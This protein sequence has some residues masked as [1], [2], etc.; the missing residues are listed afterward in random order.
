MLDNSMIFWGPNVTTN[1]SKC[2]GLRYFSSMGGNVLALG[3][4]SLFND[5][6][7]EMIYPLLPLFLTETLGA[8]AAMLGVIE[9]IAESTASV[10]KLF[11]GWLSDRLRKRKILAVVGYTISTITRPLIAIATAGWH[12]LV[13]RFSDRVGKGVRTSPRDALLADSS[14]EAIRGKA[15]GFHRAMDHAGAVIGP[16][17][18]TAILAWITISYRTVFYLAVIPAIIG[19]LILI[20]RVVEKPPVG[21][22]A[23]A[24]KITLVNFDRP[25]RYYLGVVI[26]FT[27]GNS[28]DAFLILR[29][30]NLGVPIALIPTIWLVLHL[31]KML[32]ATPGGSLS[33]K[34][35]RKRVITLGWLVYALVYAGFA[36]ASEA[37]HAWALFVTYGLYFGL[38]EGTEKAFVADLVKPE[39]RGTAYGMFHFAVGIGA[40]PASVIMG[41]LWNAFGPAVAFGFGASLAL[42][43]TILLSLLREK[44]MRWDVTNYR[45]KK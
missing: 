17:L 5:I 4:V 33:D 32:T 11:S 24:P 19:V 2:K 29:A 28:T 3:F 37:W 6:S 43:S 36:L 30:R 25:F 40:L 21:T 12:I 27:L 45:V 8:G 9:G 31:V 38:C 39:L 23:S 1:K 7:S 20:L 41:L 10:L 44:H 18:A 26:L 13:I 22:P 34:M 16:L 15:F 42:L 14:D 35:G